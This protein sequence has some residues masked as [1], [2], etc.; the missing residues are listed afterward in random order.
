VTFSAPVVTGGAAPVSTSCSSQ[1]GWA[2][3]VGTTPVTCT[4]TDAKG[5]T[6]SCAFEVTVT[7]VPQLAATRFVAFGDSITEGKLT[8]CSTPTLTGATS[9]TRYQLW[10]NDLRAL[11]LNAEASPSAYPR[12]L[13]GMLA[14]RYTQ[15]E[16]TVANEGLGGECTIGCEFN[17]VDRLPG[18]LAADSP[19]VLL[20]QEGINNVNSNLPSGIPNVITGLRMMIEQAK[21]RGV[22]VMLG[23]LLPERAG[24]CRARAPDLVAPANDAIRQLAQTEGVDIVDLYGAFAEATDALLGPDGL[25]PNAA[26]YQKIAESFFEAIKG[27]VE[28]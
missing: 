10:L 22:T 11:H 26:G 6:A 8:D 28:R 17:G 18:V 21:G 5:Q 7:K 13:Q 12:Q 20:L 3:P 19:G 9:E 15:Q 16:V 23:T 4:A 1:S 24:A 25:H 14:N 2:Y 27:K